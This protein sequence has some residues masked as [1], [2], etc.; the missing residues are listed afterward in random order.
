MIILF[1]EYKEFNGYNVG[2]ILMSS[3]DG[4]IIVSESGR[5]FRTIHFI[6]KDVENINFLN[7]TGYNF[8]EISRYWHRDD[9]V[10][11]NII[12]CIE[13]CPGVLNIV[14]L[15]MKRKDSNFHKELI[16]VWKSYDELEQYIEMDKYNI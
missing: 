7:V 1:E 15:I 3:Y 9:V 13:R 10:T 4:I 12:E 14:H 5:M 8:D 16:D 6:I 2:D 11:M